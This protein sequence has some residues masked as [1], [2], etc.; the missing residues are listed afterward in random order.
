MN[1]YYEQNKEQ[2]GPIDEGALKLLV[3]DGV[4]TRSN[5]IW[6]E[7][8]DDWV[9]YGEVFQEEGNFSGDDSCP[10]CGAAVSS[11]ALIPAGE[12]TVCPNCREDYLQRLQE[13]VSIHASSDALEIRNAHIKHEASLR[14]VGI[15]Y[16]LGAFFT[17]FGG[18]SFLFTLANSPSD[19]SSTGMDGFFIGIMVFYIILGVFMI[20]VGRGF[21]KLKRWVRVAGSILSG[22]GLLSIPIGTIINGYILYLIWSQKGK[23]ILSEEYQDVIAATPEVKYKTS[24]LVIGFLVLIVVLLLFALVIPVFSS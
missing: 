5:L 3:K 10:N 16:Y 9:P 18:L 22:L 6:R 2:K 1:W 20:I 8:F 23:M 13:G 12:A 11:D 19:L 7:G 24:P 21:R 4:I 15:L 14:S 17:L